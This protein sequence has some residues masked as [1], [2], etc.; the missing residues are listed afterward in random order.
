MCNAYKW[1]MFVWEIEALAHKPA[2]GKKQ[3]LKEC[4]CIG[5]EGNLTGYEGFNYYKS[6]AEILCTSKN[7]CWGKRV[8]PVSTRAKAMNGCINRSKA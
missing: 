7:E 4:P 6:G 8:V 1:G 3:C 2:E 5:C